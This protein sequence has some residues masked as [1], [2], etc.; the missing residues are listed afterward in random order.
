M[1]LLIINIGRSHNDTRTWAN[2]EKERIVG[3]IRTR[4]PAFPFFQTKKVP[5]LILQCGTAHEASSI[6]MTCPHKPYYPNEGRRF[7]SSTQNGAPKVRAMPGAG[8][9]A[10]EDPWS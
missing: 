4:V 6:H 9:V 1:I 3:V 5:M 7:F 8:H 10:G 2:Q